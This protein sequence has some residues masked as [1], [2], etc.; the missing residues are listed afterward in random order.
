MIYSFLSC[1]GGVGKTTLAVNTALSISQLGKNVLL[2]D[3]NFSSP[4]LRYHLALPSS[5][6]IQNINE[7]QSLEELMHDYS[8]MKIIPSSPYIDDLNKK[9]DLKKVINQ[10][11]DN[12]DIILIDGPPGMGDDVLNCVDVS[13]GIFLVANPELPTIVDTFRFL[14]NKTLGSKVLGV[15]LNKNNVKKSNMND[16]ITNKFSVKVLASI[17]LDNLIP[18][19]LILQ[20]PIVGLY[21]F[22]RSAI[23][24]KRFSANLVNADYL[25]PN[26][27][28]KAFE[29][30]KY[31]FS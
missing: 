29:G 3:G 27:F 16:E 28:K 8:G 13:T 1:K 10:V 24:I 6:N 9:V 5:P 7:S 11:K 2:I 25:S 21:P 4:N 19:S 23:E 30:L 18:K 26:W 20:K 31:K 12:F 15:I 17:S 14:L 22:S